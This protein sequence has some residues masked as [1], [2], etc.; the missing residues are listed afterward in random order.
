LWPDMV[1][2]HQTL[3]ATYRALGEIQKSAGELAEVLRIKQRNR[4]AS[5][6]APFPVEN[7]LFAVRPHR[8]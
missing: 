6:T 4:S 5:E 2:A 1:E 3:S 8:P 7:F